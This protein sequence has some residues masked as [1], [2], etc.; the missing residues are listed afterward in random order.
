MKGPCLESISRT[1]RRTVIVI[2]LIAVGKVV[3]FGDVRLTQ[4]TIRF[5]FAIEDDTNVAV[6]ANG[7]FVR[8]RSASL[9]SNQNKVG[10]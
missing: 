4:G 2:V 7:L 5:L 9:L 6:R 1:N 3:E 10:T 8:V